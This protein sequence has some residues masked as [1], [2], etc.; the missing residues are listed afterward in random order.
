MNE[1]DFTGTYGSYQG[2]PVPSIRA[3]SPTGIQN[4]PTVVARFAEYIE[5]QR[6]DQA[7]NYGLLF[8]K[9][10]YDGQAQSATQQYYRQTYEVEVF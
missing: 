2:L 6:Q 1:T 8:Y 5:M 7:H 4:L 9:C 3:T 10:G